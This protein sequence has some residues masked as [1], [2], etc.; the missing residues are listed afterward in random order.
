[1]TS[2]SSSASY[3]PGV[4]ARISRMASTHSAPR[5]PEYTDEFEWAEAW[6]RENGVTLPPDTSELR[7]LRNFI[8]NQLNRYRKGKLSEQML[9]RLARHGIDF[10][11]YRA[12]N[13]G[14]GTRD[15]DEPYIAELAVRQESLGTYDLDADAPAA[16]VSYQKRLLDQFYASGRTKRLLVIESQ[17]PGLCF[18]RW[19]K[20]TDTRAH[21]DAWWQQATDFRAAAC[22]TP[23]FRGELH[24]DTPP[25]LLAWAHEQRLRAAGPRGT[26]TAGQ[27]GELIDLGILDTKGARKVHKTRQRARADLG[28]GQRG[29]P[30]DQHLDTFLGAA[31][32]ARMLVLGRPLLAM[33]T[34]FAIAPTPLQRLLTEVAAQRTALAAM[35]VSNV[36][37]SLPVCRQLDALQPGIFSPASLSRMEPDDRPAALTSRVEEIG[38]LVEQMRAAA[39]RLQLPQDLA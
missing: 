2:T 6:V 16:L 39:Q 26:I 29:A 36:R 4:V 5:P 17:L 14:R 15:D 22:A 18:G 37:N 23:A 27:R 19:R 20:P 11:Q 10:S 12:L 28:A 7:K 13:T 24:P 33:C 25:A 9:V 8:N 32:L 31:C 34:E 35:T 30:V 21:D 1:M 38:R 3:T